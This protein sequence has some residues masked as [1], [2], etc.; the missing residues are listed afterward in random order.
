[1]NLGLRDILTWPYAALT[2]VYFSAEATMKLALWI[3]LVIS[4]A[5]MAQLAYGEES[6]SAF[7]NDDATNDEPIAEMGTDMHDDD[8]D[9]H[10][11]DLDDELD[12]EAEEDEQ[13][14]TPLFNELYKRSK[15]KA[16]KGE[17]GKK[18]EKGKK[19]KKGKG[20]LEGSVKKNK[21]PKN[22]K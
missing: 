5:G 10:D 9:D 4:F 16:G 3:F 2:V 19:G 7:S 17:Q 12:D 15:K 8:D 18:G 21:K 11:H 6:V 14:A 1:M 22:K 13:Q 20:N